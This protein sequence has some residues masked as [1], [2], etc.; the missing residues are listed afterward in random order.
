M[1]HLYRLILGAGAFLLLHTP[2]FAQNRITCSSNDGR[3]NYCNADTSSGVRLTRQFSGSPCN[4][5]STWGYERGRIWV[6]RGCR[7]E[8]EVG[9]S[10][11]GG[12]NGGWGNNGRLTCSSNDGRRAFCNADT[13]GGVR[14]VRQISGSPCN[15][16]STWGYDRN[17]VW[18]DRGCR[19][20]F[21]SGNGGGGGG[22]GGSNG[23]KTIITCSSND[24]KRHWCAA[25]TDRYGVRL[26]RQISGSPCTRG[27]TWGTDSGSV[28]VDRG[29]RA[30]FEVVVP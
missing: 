10:N 27:S 18:V 15:Q 23:R 11:G 16:G 29:C 13:R 17:G 6:D 3:R 5:G 9:R 25:D 22:W 24:G 19:A 26:V 20:E 2:A 14:L 12:N 28:W 8:F 7:A 4:Q 1:R 21:A 30:E